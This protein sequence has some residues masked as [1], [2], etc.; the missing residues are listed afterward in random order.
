LSVLPPIP[1]D[2]RLPADVPSVAELIA[3]G[4]LEGRSRDLGFGAAA[5]DES[6]EIV[7]QPEPR[8][9]ASL[10]AAGIEGR[11]ELEYVVDTTGQVVPGSI[12]AVASTHPEFE[13]AARASVLATRYRPARLQGRLVRQLVRQALGFRTD[14]HRLTPSRSHGCCRPGP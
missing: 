5:V 12:R 8:Y 4:A 10:A 9:P 14:V 2:T 3:R 7:E 6:V 1:L 13:A 11:V